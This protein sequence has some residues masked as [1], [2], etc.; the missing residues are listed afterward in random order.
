MKKPI[1]RYLLKTLIDDAIASTG[2]QAALAR[3]LSIN[4]GDVNDM[5]HERRPLTP[6]YAALLSAV[7]GYSKH[8]ARKMVCLALMEQAGTDER[9]QVLSELL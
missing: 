1:E 6:L 2:S 5:V 3:R 7:A 8:D 4:A 9:R